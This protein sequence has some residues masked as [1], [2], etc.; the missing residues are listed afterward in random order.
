MSEEKPITFF[1]CS[2]SRRR[3]NP[4]KFKCTKCEQYFESTE[5]WKSHE[6]QPSLNYY[7]IPEEKK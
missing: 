5:E 6:C 7:A 1:I 3:E 4:K 2:R